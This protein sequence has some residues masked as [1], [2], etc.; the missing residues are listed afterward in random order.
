MDRVFDAMREVILQDLGLDLARGS[1]YRLQLVDDLNA[2]AVFLNHA[3]EAADLAFDA[4]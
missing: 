2:I 1:H 3:D 4:L